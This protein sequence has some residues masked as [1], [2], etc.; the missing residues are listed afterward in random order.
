MFCFLLI[1]YAYH[2]TIDT[3]KGWCSFTAAHAESETS[4]GRIRLD[5]ILRPKHAIPRKGEIMIFAVNN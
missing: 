4:L 1:R 2:L 3:D 5:S